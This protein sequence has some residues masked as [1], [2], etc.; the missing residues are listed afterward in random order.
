MEGKVGDV[1]RTTAYAFMMVNFRSQLDWALRCTSSWLNIISGCEKLAFE[2]MGWV[3]QTALPTVGRTLP[4]FEGLNRRKRQRKV[5]FSLCLLSWHID[6][7][8]PLV[9]LVLRPQ[10]RIYSFGSLTLRP[11]NPIFGFPLFQ[12]HMAVCR[13]SLPPCSHANTL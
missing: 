2:S 9:L 5:K 1:Y 12:G 4:S 13:T 3:K 8:L 7:F 11:S 10:T 6:L